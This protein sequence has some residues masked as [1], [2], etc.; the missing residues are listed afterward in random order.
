MTWGKSLATYLVGVVLLAGLLLAARDSLILG[1][2]AAAVALSFAI[3]VQLGPE[4]A[5][6]L[7]VTI[8]LFCGPMGGATPLPGAT[9]VTFAD[10]FLVV[11]FGLLAPGFFVHRFQLPPLY[12][13]G[14]TLAVVM[15]IVATLNAEDPFVSANLFA[16]FLASVVILPIAFLLWA[17]SIQ[18]TVNLA[19]AY[20]LGTVFSTGW[21]LVEGTAADTGRYI[22]LTEH[23]NAFGLTGVLAAALIPFIVS[24]TKPSWQWL[25]WGVGAIHLFAI[26]I[27]GSR[28]SL[29]V[30][31]ALIAL[32]VA[33]ERSTK[34]VGW[35]M[36]AAL[37][38]LPFAERLLTRSDNALGRLLGGGSASN[39][40]I[41]REQALDKG[42]KAF[43]EH[44]LLGNGFEDALHAHN[45][46]LQIAVCIGVFGLVGWVLILLAT[47]LPLVSLPRPL[48]RIGYPAIGYA[49]TALLTSL[50]W[51]R[52][53]WLVLV[54]ALVV[55]ANPEARSRA[56][57]P[58]PENDERPRLQGAGGVRKR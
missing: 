24:H 19:R 57:E 46:Y 5:G 35:L 18:V 51:D 20:A 4:R 15:G 36:A 42:I 14:V 28:A 49:M 47:C 54:L 3:C 31:I 29:L 45:V 41:E 1:A 33:V 48:H 30:I 12:L 43:F 7:F 53:I 39:S 50:I 44:P 37:L 40:D 52:Y 16:R 22:G 58:D 2:V 21:G 17:P 34:A 13:A 32:Y 27:S 56:A 10:I 9:F 6:T 11:G 55:S 8:A 38:V 23:P 26:W 25:W